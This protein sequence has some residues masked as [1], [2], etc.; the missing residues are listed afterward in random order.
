M[1]R[2]LEKLE[3]QIE[4]IHKSIEILPEFRDWALEN[5]KRDYHQ[6]IEE[7]EIFYNNLQKDLKTQEL[8]LDNLTDALLENRIEKDDFDRRKLSIKKDIKT[9]EQQL[10]GMSE[11]RDEKIQI[12]EEY[13]QFA[14]TA[15]NTFNEWDVQVRRNIFNSLGQNFVLQD[16]ILTIELHPWVQPLKDNVMEL[17]QEYKRFETNKKGIVMGN[18][19]TFDVF[20]L[21]W[22]PQGS[23]CPTPL[24]QENKEF[25]RNFMRVIEENLLTFERVDFKYL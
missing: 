24:V 7:R 23:E 17:T 20:F 15:V 19:N 3:A 8:K 11:R 6:E 16:W 10:W 25:F 1:V 12:V 2:T 22:Q 4:D 14:N 18:N 5:I 13:F 9:I 21:K